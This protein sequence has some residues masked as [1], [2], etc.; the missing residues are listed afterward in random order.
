MFRS[1]IATDLLPISVPAVRAGLRVANEHR[2][3]TVVIYVLEIWMIDRR[4][5]SDITQE[6]I[7]PNR[8]LM[9]REEEAA[10]ARR[11]GGHRP[12]PTTSI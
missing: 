11:L 7:A 6:D 10:V 3:K 9:E 12:K 8:S 2:S 5:L 1:L 4:W